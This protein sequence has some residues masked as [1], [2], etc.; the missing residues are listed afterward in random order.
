MTII[1]IVLFEFAAE[2]DAE[3]VNDVGPLILS[4]Q[5]AYR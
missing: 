5:V 2:A 1:H 4:S 3:A